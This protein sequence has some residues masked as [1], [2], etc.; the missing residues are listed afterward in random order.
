MADD[1]AKKALREAR[2][3]IVA[4]HRGKVDQPGTLVIEG[5]RAYSASQAEIRR[6]TPTPM[7]LRKRAVAY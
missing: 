5:V 1:K 6:I 4:V 2:E 7:P 3:A